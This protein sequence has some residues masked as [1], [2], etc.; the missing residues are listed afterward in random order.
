MA[1]AGVA[2]RADEPDGCP[3]DTRAPGPVT[4]EAAARLSEHIMA[5]VA[6]AA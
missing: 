3:V 2:T 5:A 1:G 4:R 6:A